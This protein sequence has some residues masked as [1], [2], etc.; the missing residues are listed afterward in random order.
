MFNLFMFHHTLQR[1]VLRVY[2]HLIRIHFKKDKDIIKPWI[3]IID[4][5]LYKHN[6]FSPIV[7]HLPTLAL[8]PSYI[9]LRKSILCLFTY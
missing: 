2:I 8:P 9:L 6:F 1:D 5:K 7:P 3:V 4:I